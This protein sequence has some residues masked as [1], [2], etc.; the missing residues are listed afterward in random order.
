VHRSRGRPSVRRIDPKTRA[1]I[2]DRYQER[3]GDFGPALAA[4]HLAK[5]GFAVDDETLRWWLIEQG[6]R[7]KGRRCQQHRQWG[8]RKEHQGE[9][10]E[11]DGSLHDWFEGRRDSAV[12]RVMIDDASNWTYARFFEQETTAAA[13]E[14]F[15]RYV[16]RRGLPCAL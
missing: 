16:R 9:M 13:Y 8:E 15:E 5:E 2:V 7:S 4:E 3:Y 6:I 14:T 1:G 11:M 10:V 12:L